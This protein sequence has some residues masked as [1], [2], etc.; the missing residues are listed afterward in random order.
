MKTSRYPL[1]TAGVGVFLISAPPVFA[2]S[3]GDPS[4]S[5]SIS[6]SSRSGQQQTID[7]SQ[8]PQPART[9]QAPAP[10]PK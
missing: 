8:V 10:V 1:L 5:E 7:I 9:A 3:T 4:T 6:K 2:Q